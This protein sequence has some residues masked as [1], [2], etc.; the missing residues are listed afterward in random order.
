MVKSGAERVKAAAER[1]PDASVVLRVDG[2]PVR[3]AVATA[4]L[5]RSIE[6]DV[7]SPLGLCKIAAGAKAK[8]CNQLSFV[9]EP[10]FDLAVI[11]AAG[12]S[13]VP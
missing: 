2:P 13:P 3:R 6:P 11:A 7:A 1:P 5:P 10:D 8:G 12:E 4:R 9:D